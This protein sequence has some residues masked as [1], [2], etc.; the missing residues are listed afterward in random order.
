MKFLVLD[1]ELFVGRRKRF[2]ELM[3]EGIA[4]IPT[5][6]EVIRNGRDTYFP[7]R[8]DSDFY[9]LTGFSESDAVLVVI[10][11]KNARSILFCKKKNK[12]KEKWTG[13]LYG[14]KKA[15]I[16]FG[17]YE[18]FE[19]EKLDQELPKLLSQEKYLF[20]DWQ[21]LDWS[22]RV[23]AW[24]A[25][26]RNVLDFRNPKSIL[27][28]MRLIKSPAE[29]LTMS[30]AAKISAL[31]HKKAMQ[32]CKPEMMEYELEAE[33]V[34]EFRFHGSALLGAYTPIVASGNNACTLHYVKNN[35]MMES[36]NLVLVDA[37]SEIGNYA[38]DITR[39]FPVNG[40][41]T[42]EQRIIYG[43]V[44]KSQ[45][46]AIGKALPGNSFL[47]PD[48]EARKVITRELLKIGLLRGNPRTLIKKNACAKFFPHGTS[49]WLGFDVHDVGNYQING[50]PR[51]LEP[52]MVLT[53]EPGIY[54]PRGMQ[55]VDKKWW[56]IGVRIEDDVLITEKGNE[57]LSKDAPKSV[58]EIERTVGTI[59]LNWRI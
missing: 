36:G 14:P 59:D 49:H 55:G 20:F 2:A 29:I 30:Y 28:E 5:S 37:G 50:K 44:L 56:G 34:R 40:K 3:R 27:H 16:E 51:K 23:R 31:A 46:A 12:Q 9:Y 39:T 8:P 43:I 1:K 41:F 58:E 6:S 18:A 32:I 26:T 45:L 57:V 38:S 25:G 21:N 17:F 52:G 4:I 7:H 10:A 22:N 33:L 53:V 48:K 47:E 15:Q 19:L 24:L 54:I 35:R 11:G 13:Y 42:K